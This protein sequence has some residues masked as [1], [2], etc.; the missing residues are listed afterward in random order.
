[1]ISCD[2]WFTCVMIPDYPQFQGRRLISKQYRCCIL[3]P[4]KS[5]ICV[6]TCSGVTSAGIV[7]SSA[8]G[9]TISGNSSLTK[10]KISEVF[11]TPLSP[12]NKIRTSCLPTGPIFFIFFFYKT[13]VKSGLLSALNVLFVT[14]SST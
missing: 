10:D 13:A 11:P 5:T 1:M 12:N 3:L 4:E 8:R 2:H 14:A 7:I 9:G 6:G